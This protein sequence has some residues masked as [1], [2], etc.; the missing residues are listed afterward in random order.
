MAERIFTVG[1]IAS[2]KSF[3]GRKKEIKELSG[4]IFESVAAINLVG[5][6]RI[7]KSSLVEKVFQE[8]SQVANRL[9]I[10]MVMGE[11]KDAFSFWTSLA[12][13]VEEA[14]LE[15]ELWNNYF[16]YK[17]AVINNL[18]MSNEGWY[19][20]FNL[21]FGSVLEKIGKKNFRVVLAIDEFDAV[22]GVF[23]KNT[24]YYQF[25]RSIFSEPKYSTSGVLISRRR[26]NLIDASCDNISTFHGVFK[27]MSLRPFSNDDMEDFYSALKNYCG[28]ELTAEGKKTFIDFTG[29]MPYLCCMFGDRMTNEDKTSCDDKDVLEI[30]KQCLPQ[31][32]RH[33]DDLIKHLERDKQLEYIGGLVLGNTLS[34]ITVSE[35]NDF[36][37]DDSRKLENL[38]QMGILIDDEKENRRYVFSKDFLAYFIVSPPKLPTWD[39]IMLA[40]IKLK[41]IFGEVFPLLA[42]THYDKF[43]GTDASEIQN[44]INH[45]Y[46]MLRLN[47]TQIR[48]YASEPLTRRRNPSIVDVLT[49]SYIVDVI[50]DLWSVEIRNKNK[51][52][53]DYFD[54]DLIW[55][56]KKLGFIKEVRKALAHPHVSNEGIEA[57]DR[58]KC[59][60]YCEELCRLIADR[61]T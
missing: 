33:Y 60:M 49:L 27:E 23:Q 38:Q 42:N 17:F 40:E 47:W 29:R 50:I 52:F 7:G 6:T 37:I 54:K 14:L 61:K 51:R 39:S 41:K 31:I 25:L 58:K 30:F 18:Q 26:L 32:N 21:N 53:C 44:K 46:T 19:N 5:P 2:G 8:N 1:P 15:S 12:Y 13:N 36:P 20:I 10:R 4:A 11:Q 24:A 45:K 3:F 35:L 55:K 43:N 16:E 34:E 56:E 22:A 28:I 59:Q 48:N 9:C 57:S